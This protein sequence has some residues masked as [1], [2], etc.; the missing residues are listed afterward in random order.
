MEKKSKKK[1]WKIEESQGEVIKRSKRI[2]RRIGKRN[3][4]A[5]GKRNSEEEVK[6]IEE[7]EVNTKQK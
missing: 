4:I 1:K 7:G 6:G 2:R 3:R 5:R